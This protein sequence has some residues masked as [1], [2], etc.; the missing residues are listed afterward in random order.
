[1]SAKCLYLKQIGEIKMG[2]YFLR[3]KKFSFK[4]VIRAD[5]FPILWQFLW[6][7]RDLNPHGI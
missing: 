5:I 3:Y 1:M 4:N 2:F 7:R 6:A